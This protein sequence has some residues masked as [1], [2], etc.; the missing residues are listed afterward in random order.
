[1]AVNDT[2]HETASDVA[3]GGEFIIDASDSET[4]G[5]EV[6]ELG[7]TNEAE[8]Y[9]ETDT[10]DD[11]NYDLSVLIDVASGEWHSQKNQLVVSESERHRIRVVNVSGESSDYYA[12]GMEVND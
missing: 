5:V 11:G 1:M 3:D 8:V 2:F 4:G 10:D 12:T 7:G 9:R 6:F